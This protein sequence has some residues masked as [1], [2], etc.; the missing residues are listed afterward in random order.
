MKLRI[1][2]LLVFLSLCISLN[3]TNGIPPKFEA[4]EFITAN[5]SFSFNK[6]FFFDNENELLFIDFEAITDELVMLNIYREGNLMMED[7]VTDL[8]N[9][10]IYEINTNVIREG[11]YTIELVTA[12]D[13]KIRKEIIV[14]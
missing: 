12:E 9:D 2:N 1:T 10:V 4:L 8:P 3:A 5:N 13:I 11:I 7:D 6:I 14:N